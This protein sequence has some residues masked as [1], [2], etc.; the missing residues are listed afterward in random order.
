MLPLVCSADDCATCDSYGEFPCAWY[1]IAFVVVGL[2]GQFF[3]RGLYDDTE[4]TYVRRS[5]G[6]VEQ[7]HSCGWRSGDAAARHHAG[8]AGG[9]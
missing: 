6:L 4:V 5:T 9:T 3:T 2:V 8:G 1:K 7:C